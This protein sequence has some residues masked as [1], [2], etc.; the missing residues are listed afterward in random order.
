MHCD[1]KLARV[2]VGTSREA[3]VL[4]WGKAFAM[5]Q[6]RADASQPGRGLRALF[7]LAPWRRVATATLGHLHA[8]QLDALT[9]RL[10]LLR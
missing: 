8:R 9:G 3:F 5:A 1:L 6:P 4:G 10:S 2:M 7:T